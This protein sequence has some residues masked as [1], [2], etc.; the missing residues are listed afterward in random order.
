MVI[1][2]RKLWCQVVISSQGEGGTGNREPS[3]KGLISKANCAT[4]EENLREMENFQR[5]P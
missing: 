5:E 2:S 1:N 3:H 4:T